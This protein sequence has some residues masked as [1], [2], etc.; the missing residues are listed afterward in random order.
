M[1]YRHLKQTFQR[2]KLRSSSA[3]NAAQELE[4]PLLGLWAMGLFAC[5]ELARAK[6]L[7]QSLSVSG[8]LRAFRRLMHDP[9]HPADSKRPLCR[10]LR[11]ALVDDYVRQNKQSRDDPRKKPHT[12]TGPPHIVPATPKQVQQAN[13]LK[14]AM[15]AKKG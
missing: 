5:V 10:Q 1:F 9:L 4:W 6:I 3:A 15:A 12:R 14:N 8:V 13:T 11:E 2:R 7:L